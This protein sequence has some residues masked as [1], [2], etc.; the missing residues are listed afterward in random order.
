MVTDI[1]SAPIL[2]PLLVEVA[3]ALGNLGLISIRSTRRNLASA[4]AKIIGEEQTFDERWP[5]NRT[6]THSDV[7]P[8][9]KNSASRRC[10]GYRDFWLVLEAI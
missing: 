7:A 2:S 3:H 8:R 4:A 10:D 1:E 5:V 6:F 9:I